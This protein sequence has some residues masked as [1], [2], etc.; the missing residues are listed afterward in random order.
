VKTVNQSQNHEISYL[1]LLDLEWVRK[2]ILVC[3]TAFIK[4]ISIKIHPSSNFNIKEKC[5][6]KARSMNLTLSLQVGTKHWL[7]QRMSMLRKRRI[8]RRDE[9]LMIMGEYTRNLEMSPRI[10]P[11]KCRD[12]LWKIPNISQTLTIDKSYN[13][14]RIRKFGSL[15]YPRPAGIL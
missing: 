3:L 8:K 14:H 15:N 2:A 6:P 1:E 12:S 10:L 4:V 11:T 7:S 9:N 5:I 13:N